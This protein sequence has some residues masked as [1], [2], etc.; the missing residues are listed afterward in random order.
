MVLLSASLLRTQSEAFLAIISE[1]A[2]QIGLEI[3]KF[4]KQN[5]L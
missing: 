4:L 5:S 2:L 1:I 3:L